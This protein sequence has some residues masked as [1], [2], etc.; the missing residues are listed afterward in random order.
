ML[1]RVAA[2]LDELGPGGISTLALAYLSG[3]LGLGLPVFWRAREVV[4][5]AAGDPPGAAD[6]ILVLGR[7]LVADRPT[8]VFDARL[9]HAR[10]LLDAGW[11]PRILVSGGITGRAS[12]SEAAAGREHLLARGVDSE[13]IW[14]EERSRH[15]LENLVHVRETLRR[16]GLRRLL[17]VSDPL[18]LA[19][20]ATLARGL[21]LDLRCSPALA[22]P[23]RRGSLGWWL[24][25]LREGFLLHWY[26]VGVAY[27]RAIRSE[28]LLARVR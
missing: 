5:A 11:A 9:E 17:L 28:R 14:I 8:A 1:R 13:R 6:V 10:A 23:P 25:A 26:H 27:S 24:R 20:A 2:F 3:L 19:R 22:A 16:E 12:R 15:T 7:V 21:A 18:H 4:A